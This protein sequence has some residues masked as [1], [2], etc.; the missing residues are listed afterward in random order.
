LLGANHGALRESDAGAAGSGSP[1]SL[2]FPF[3]RWINWSMSLF[4]GS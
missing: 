4:N 2:F 1:F 3:G